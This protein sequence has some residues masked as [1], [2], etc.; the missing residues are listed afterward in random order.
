MAATAAAKCGAAPQVGVYY[1][2]WYGPGSG[3]HTFDDTLR[4]HLTPDPQ[5]PAAGLNGRDASVVERHI[6]QSHTGNIS[7]WSLSWWGPGGFEDITIRNHILTHP[8]APELQYTIHYESAG[9]MAPID[10][11]DYS[12]LLPDFR[13]LANHIWSDPNYMRIDGRPVVFMYLTREFFKTPESWSLLSDTR[14]AIAQEYGYAPY[15]IGDDFFGSSPVDTARA[16]QFDAITNF[17]VYGTV[18]GGGFANQSRVNALASIYANAKAAAA[19]AG[20]GFVPT[21]SPGFND[22]AVRPGPAPAARYLAELGPNANGSTF[23]TVLEDAVLP[24]TDPTV[25]DLIMINSFNEWHED[26]QIEASVLAALT[27]SDDSSTG[28][29]FTRGRYDEGYGSLYLDLLRT[30]TVLA[31]DYNFDGAVDPADYSVWRADYNHTGIDVAADGNRDGTV[32]AADYVVWRDALAAVGDAR[33]SPITVPEPGAR[34]LAS[35]LCLTLGITP[36][37]RFPERLGFLDALIKSRRRP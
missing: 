33:N 32:D 23:T 21:A 11:P 3:G 28:A 6:D 35:A 7:M 19:A 25:G 36:S 12:N 8:R 34:L 4:A 10:S 13:H 31:G 5:L 1:Y 29:A 9:R 15:I 24:N 17:D 37:R 14:E 2:P 22:T 18:F 26:T 27:N 20:V 16:A 30:A